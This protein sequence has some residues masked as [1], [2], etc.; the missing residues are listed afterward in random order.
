MTAENRQFIVNFSC[1]N[2]KAKKNII[3]RFKNDNCPLFDDQN[4]LLKF[5]NTTEKLTNIIQ[6]FN[7]VML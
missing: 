1:L 6:P 5:Y 7:S 2:N 3:I 4:D